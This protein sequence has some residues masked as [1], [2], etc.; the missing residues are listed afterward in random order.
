MVQ[1]IELKLIGTYV[2]FILVAIIVIFSV[3]NSFMM[4]IFERMPEFGMLMAV[5]MRVRHIIIQLQIEA[6][7]VC[8]LGI[9]LGLVITG[10]GIGI[11]SETG[12]P[13]P[14]LADEVFQA[15]SMPDRMY[16]VFSEG[17]LY[18]CHSCDAVGNAACRNHPGPATE[19]PSG[20]SG[21]AGGRIAHADNT[22]NATECTQHYSASSTQSHAFTG[23]CGSRL[24]CHDGEHIHSRY[25]A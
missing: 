20:R 1:M 10:L 14:E 25:A 13:L 5:G 12:I 17:S 16:P 4:I 24:H 15:M 6:L 21:F 8:L 9:V 2:M 23:D 3:V 19:T 7:F 18:F 22:V 11:L